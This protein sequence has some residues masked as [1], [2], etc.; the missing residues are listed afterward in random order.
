MICPG[1]YN[2][3]EL[4][5]PFDQMDYI[6]SFWGFYTAPRNEILGVSK[7][8]IIGVSHKEMDELLFSKV[9]T[10]EGAFTTLFRTAK[11]DSQ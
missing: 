8:L 3:L 5:N 10:L 9:I 6:L 2:K 7:N 4:H 1:Y 11:T